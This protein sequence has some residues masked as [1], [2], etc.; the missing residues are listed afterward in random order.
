M[1][2]R[3]F[4]VDAMRNTVL[5][6]SDMVLGARKHGLTLVAGG[7][8]RLIRQQSLSR[9]CCGHMGPRL[10]SNQMARITSTI[11]VCRAVGMET[12][13]E[14][15]SQRPTLSEE[16][17]RKLTPLHA[18]NIYENPALPMIKTVN[19]LAVGLQ[20]NLE[21]GIVSSSEDE[22]RNKYGANSV[23]KPEPPSVFKLILDAL[24][25]F[26]VLTLI[27]AGVV[28]LGLELWLAAK[29][30]REANVI[31]S[32]SILAAVAVVVLVSAG[33]NWQKERQFRALE[34]VQSK[35][36]VRAI[37]D[38][39]EISLPVER[40]VVGDLLMLE[41]GDILCADGVLVRGFN[42]RCENVC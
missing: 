19:D 26:T 27:G 9:C 16:D 8:Q 24:N 13:R 33:N 14:E 38:G 21:D 12:S 40:V 5:I 41:T 28:S 32:V 25:E 10:L 2:D 1:L 11:A 4:A 31:E 17:C 20:T 7:V 39:V 30:G 22:R 3:T 42:I 37:R 35:S 34:E 18:G 23:A 15:T 29:E 36:V 6:Q